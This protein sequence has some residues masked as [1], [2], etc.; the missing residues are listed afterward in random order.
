MTTLALPALSSD[1]GLSTYL[2]QIQRFPMLSEHEEYALARRW[3]EDQDAEAAHKLVTS[4]LRLVAKIALR[5]RGYGLPASDL[6]SERNVGLMRAVKKFDPERG[7]RF[8][9]YAMW[10]IKA[11]VTEF[12]LDSWSLVRT[13]T[14]D[15]QKRLF[16]ALKKAK[17]RLNIYDSGQL[18]DES[19]ERLA[20]KLGQPV[21]KVRD[22]NARLTIRDASLNQRIGMDENAPE[23]IELLEDDR[24]TPEEAVAEGQEF[25]FRR[26][27]L[28]EAVRQLPERDRE[29]VQARHLSDEPKTLS[30]LAARYGVSRERIRQIEER[31][32]KKIRAAIQQQ[33][34][35]RNS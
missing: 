32:L 10:W 35:E 31:A 19:A 15:T 4:H 3:Q 14:R 34:G 16:F 24:A 33:L 8:A 21:E 20:K 6:V 2:R 26:A 23:H 11:A 18:S 30:E 1:A 9:T 5:Y 28:R 7:V 13:G 12:I 22:F 25:H 17:A 29:I 27:L